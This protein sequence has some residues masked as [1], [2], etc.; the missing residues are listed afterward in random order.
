MPNGRSNWATARAAC[1][2]LGFGALHSSWRPDGGAH[3]AWEQGV[4]RRL[5]HA[6][7]IAAEASTPAQA[8]RDKTEQSSLAVLL[9]SYD[10]AASAPVSTDSARFGGV[11]LAMGMSIAS[12]L[13]QTSKRRWFGAFAS[14]RGMMAENACRKSC[15]TTKAFDRWLMRTKKAFRASLSLATGY[16]IPRASQ[17]LVA[18][19][20]AGKLR[21]QAEGSSGTAQAAARHHRA[22]S[23][24]TPQWQGLCCQ[25]PHVAPWLGTGSSKLFDYIGQALLSTRA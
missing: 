10:V 7:R 5:P 24:S 21:K 16:L 11:G 25:A 3:L 15:G 13:L 19:G 1:E 20:T 23:R 9:R 18:Q 8:R 17:D 6:R 12:F 14:R 4:H 2:Q 22:A